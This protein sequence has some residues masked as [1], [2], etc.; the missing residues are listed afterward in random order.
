MDA[1]RNTTLSATTIRVGLPLF[2]QSVLAPVT[3]FV[4]STMTLA[5]GLEEYYDLPELA[6]WFSIIHLSYYLVAYAIEF[7]APIPASIAN[8]WD[9]LGDRPFHRLRD[10][11]VDWYSAR[12]RNVEPAPSTCGQWPGAQR[13]GRNSMPVP[14]TFGRWL[15][16]L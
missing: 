8:E 7:L 4:A 1:L 10:I 12:K 3:V 14:S 11:L 6:W 5:L 16:F 13:R 2:L 15:L 9:A